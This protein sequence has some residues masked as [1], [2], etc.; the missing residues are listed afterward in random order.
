[1]ARR[2]YQIALT[3]AFAL[4]AVPA[5]GE[6][7]AYSFELT[8]GAGLPV[9]EAL[10]EAARTATTEVVGKCDLTTPGY[11]NK[12]PSR[13]INWQVLR[14]RLGAE[15]RVPDWRRLDMSRRIDVETAT[16]ALVITNGPLMASSFG[17]N[18][19]GDWSSLVSDEEIW[20]RVRRYVDEGGLPSDLLLYP[21]VLKAGPPF[22]FFSA[23]FDYGGTKDEAIKLEVV[24]EQPKICF[25]ERA[26]PYSTIVMDSL[27]NL[28][29]SV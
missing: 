20:S 12:P 29:V 8:K 2:T 1:M 7:T 13:F 10:L 23:D 18:G 24:K 26:D 22:R 25:E 6:E 3:A 11:E 21:E 17:P 19:W 15:F 5:A 14:D 4:L 16:F 28:P 9:C 27:K